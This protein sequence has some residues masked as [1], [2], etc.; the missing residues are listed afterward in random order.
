MKSHSKSS[1]HSHSHSKK[2]HR[3]T[4]SPDTHNEE[5]P[6]WDFS[7][8]SQPSIFPP[9]E[10]TLVRML[11]SNKSYNEYLGAGEVVVDENTSYYGSFETTVTALFRKLT[12]DFRNP[13]I[14]L[15]IEEILA[16]CIGA[17]YRSPDGNIE[18]IESTPI[19]FQRLTEAAE[20]IFVC[21]DRETEEF[22][23]P[24]D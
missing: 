18:T 19:Y 5:A 23:L 10:P 15:R 1:H 21:R 2:H 12:I 24:H 22:F 7:E 3:T 8:E 16:L 9:S 20:R 17:K 4:T 11:R 13:H 14:S 6:N